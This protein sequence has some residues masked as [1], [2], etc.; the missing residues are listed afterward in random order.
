MSEKYSLASLEVEVP[1]PVQQHKIN[2]HQM[3]KQEFP[4]MPALFFATE[5]YQYI[6]HYILEMF[7]S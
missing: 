4:K 7:V 5:K 1:K 2:I 3:N 6:R